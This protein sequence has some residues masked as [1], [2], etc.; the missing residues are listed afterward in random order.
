MFLTAIQAAVVCAVVFDC[1]KIVDLGSSFLFV[2]LVLCWLVYYFIVF[3]KFLELIVELEEFP[4]WL[5]HC[6]LLYEK[7]LSG[8]QMRKSVFVK[9]A[10]FHNSIRFLILCLIIVLKCVRPKIFSFHTWIHG[11][12]CFEVLG[13]EN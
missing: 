6:F 10:L 4:S 7:F 9:L 12:C 5:A 3:V 2:P 13:V 1:L 8:R 11:N